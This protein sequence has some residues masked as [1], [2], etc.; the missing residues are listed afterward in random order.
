MDDKKKKPSARFAPSRQELDEWNGRINELQ[1]GEGLDACMQ[2]LACIVDH[3]D[4]MRMDHLQCVIYHRALDWLAT[5]KKDLEAFRIIEYEN[6]CADSDGRRVPGTERAMYMVYN[7]NIVSD[8]DA[9]K[10]LASGRQD[11]DP[12]VVILWPSQAKALFPALR[13]GSEEDGESEDE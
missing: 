2:V 12:R 10:I 7:T 9:E 3:Y 1:N 6:A 5:L 13:E 4:T 11:M 8:E